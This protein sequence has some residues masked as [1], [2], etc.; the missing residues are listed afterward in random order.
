MRMWRRRRA[1]DVWKGIAAGTVGGLAASWVMSQFQSAW[2]K[3][4]EATSDGS[5]QKANGKERSLDED[6]TV[7]TAQKITE[8]FTG[9]RLDRRQKEKAGPIVHY[10]FGAA[11]GALY[12]AAAEFLPPVKSLAGV[13]YGAALFVGADEVALPV[14]GLTK[15]PTEYPASQHLYGLSSHFVYG[16]TLEGVRRVLRDRL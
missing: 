11:M 6:P 15:K 13:P 4:A 3:A 16:L 8:T 14:L 1:R 7:R 9:S 12:G 2:S 10:A 5:S